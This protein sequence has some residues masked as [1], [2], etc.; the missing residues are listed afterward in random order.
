MIYGARFDLKNEKNESPKDLALKTKN[1]K[2]TRLFKKD[3]FFVSLFNFK[4]SIKQMKSKMKFLFSILMLF[5]NS[6]YF[7]FMLLP[8][9]QNIFEMTVFLA[10]NFIIIFSFILLS[11]KN[12]SVYTKNIPKGNDH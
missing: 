5:L 8:F 12:T 1:E 2:I 4:L 11:F 10:L 3:N 6:F 7:V 9:C